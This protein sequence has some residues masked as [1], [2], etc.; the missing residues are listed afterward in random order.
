M[1]QRYYDYLVQKTEC[2]SASSTLDC[3]RQLPAQTLLDVVNTTPAQFSPHA[4]NFTW[5][6][7]VDGVLLNKTLKESIR[8]GQY[9]KVPLLGGQVDD[10]GT[11]VTSP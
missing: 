6:L 7:S 10:E 4:L 3:L 2:S 9:A 11:Y 5:S 1:N 8:L